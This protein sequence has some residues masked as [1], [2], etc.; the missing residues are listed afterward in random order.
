MKCCFEIPV[1]ACHLSPLAL[2]RFVSGITPREKHVTEDTE[3]NFGRKCILD[4]PSPIW[5]DRRL[6][7]QPSFPHPFPISFD[8]CRRYVT[9]ESC[10]VDGTNKNNPR[11]VKSVRPC[12]CRLS[13]RRAAIFQS[14][15]RIVSGARH[16]SIE[17]ALFLMLNL[18]PSRARPRSSTSLP[19]A[20]NPFLEPNLCCRRPSTCRPAQYGRSA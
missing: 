16:Q 3:K 2:Y 12:S 8:R 15:P 13:L 1:C 6:G 20:S 19:I 17:R 4:R 10:L 9:I 5:S 7:F 11:P 18:G 14:I